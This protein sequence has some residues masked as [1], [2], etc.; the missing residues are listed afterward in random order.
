[1]NGISPWA[2]SA[3]SEL[4]E[5]GHALFECST[6]SFNFKVYNTRDA[7]WVSTELPG[8]GRMAF[9][10]VFS[11]GPTLEISRIKTK[12]SRVDLWLSSDVGT[13]ETSIWIE[14]G[15]L[16]V[17]RYT[18]SLK[19]AKDLLIPFWPRDILATTR[20]GKA[21]NTAGKIHTSQWGNRTGFIYM[22]MTRPKSASI[23]YLQNLT[24]LSGYC[25]QTQT[26]AGN[27]VGGSW[28]ELGF[29]LPA[30]TEK[31]LQSG[32]KV[33]ICDAFVAF[34]DQVPE[35]EP[36]MI[37][38]YFD[39]LAKVYLLLPL[40]NTNYQPWPEI[41]E[42]GL[43][44]LIDSPGCWTQV[45]GHKYL[46]A[47]VSDYQTPPEI[48]VQLAV[49]LPLQDYVEWSTRDLE[50]MKI[51]KQG[52]PAFYDQKLGTITRWLP[53]AEDK[54][55]GEEE[56]K[57][58]GVM[59][60]WYLHHPLL[61][62][63]RLALKGDLVS[64]QLF[65]DSLDYAI[66]VARHF[67]YEWPV[68]YKMDTLEVLKAETAEGMG[69]EKDVAGIY[70]H[71]MLQAWELT[72]EKKY[73][74]EAEK[75]AQTLQ[76]KG[77]QVFYQANN[78]AFSAG[79]LL[80][81]FKITKKE[82]YLNLSYMCLAGIFRNTQLWDCNYGYGKSF[83]TFFALY[84]LNDAPYT[85]AYEEQEVFC[86]LHDYLKHAEGVDILPSVRM[87]I[88]EFIRYLVDRAV[89]YYP[90]MLP[91]D[92]LE[93]KPK[94]GEVDPK[95]WIALEDLQDGWLKS[96]TVGQEVYGA[97]NAFGI[98][99]RHYL[100]VPGEQFMIYIDYPTSGFT[101][102]KG[103]NIHFSTLGDERLTCRMKIIKTGN[104]KLPEFG[105][106]IKGQAGLLEA[107]PAE[108]GNL[109][110]VIPGNSSITISFN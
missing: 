11:P 109:E 95:L 25:E 72:L 20:S 52:L 10:P 86:A 61:N 44:D 65:L 93:D 80:R 88:A 37:R 92:M 84:P 53:A 87:L 32:K 74:N 96:G 71:V 56:Q 78:T 46:N 73:L 18:T 38:Q 110:F 76:G 48:M 9:R 47:Y 24:A 91:S 60:S 79:A 83:P 34:D 102:R 57:E 17:L 49:L 6:G 31:S 66:K 55:E 23:F 8:G 1:M 45:A 90:A 77:F 51:I 30:S 58:P 7:I 19:P 43:K 36:D 12:G 35:T 98:L 41:L 63:S 94:I 22:S 28:P 104:A 62:L 107:I 16:P 33:V 103:Q 85:A 97:G 39:L 75:A 3:A 82:V 4:A 54:L 14:H 89:Y 100:Q 99:P 5:A 40:P 70:T 68:F 50:V 64:K 81:L 13:F 108:S 26:T 105:V 67:K 101:A 106:E 42:K 2:A 59:D 27:S 21:E 15:E 69:G 29:A